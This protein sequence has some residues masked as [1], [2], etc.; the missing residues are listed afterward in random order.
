VLEVERSFGL[1]RPTGAD[2][3]N[4]VLATLCEDDQDETATNRSDGD[5]PLFQVGV[6]GVVDLEEVDF[7]REERLGFPE[8]D[9]VLGEVLA[10][11]L[12]VSL[13]PH[14]KIVGH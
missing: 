11:L 13:E 9:A 5:E 3:S 8:A 6:L 4:R 2:D 1:A 14:A 10:L 12:R 7:G